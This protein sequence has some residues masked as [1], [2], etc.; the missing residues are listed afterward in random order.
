MR[1]FPIS[2]KGLGSATPASSCHDTQQGRQVSRA[3][4]HEQADSFSLSYRVF[5]QRVDQQ[6]IS[7]NGPAVLSHFSLLLQA[8]TEHFIIRGTFQHKQM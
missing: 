3:E 4:R 7:K 6:S 2:S 1:I 8:E 5:V